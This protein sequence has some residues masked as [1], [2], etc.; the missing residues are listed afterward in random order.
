MAKLI[1]KAMLKKRK[2]SQ[3]RLAILLKMD[4]KNVARL[5]RPDYDPKLSTLN[6]LAKVLKCKV[7]DLLKE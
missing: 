4:G 1:L 5:F 3:Y 6:R 2:I 7:R